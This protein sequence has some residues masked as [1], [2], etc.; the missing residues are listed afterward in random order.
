M[1]PSVRSKALGIEI[2]MMLIL[3]MMVILMM[4]LMTR[5][6]TKPYDYD[7]DTDDDND[8]KNDSYTAAGA[9]PRASVPCSLFLF[10]CSGSF[11][12]ALWADVRD[13]WALSGST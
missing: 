5:M 9:A 8:H 11:V 1:V 12:Q 4:I 3:M 7:N 2:W 6:M 13:F 10:L